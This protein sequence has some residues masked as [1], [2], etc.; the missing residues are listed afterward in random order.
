[1]WL[2]R[3]FGRRGTAKKSESPNDQGDITGASAT[4]REYI[5]THR[6]SKAWGMLSSSTG[7]LK[8]FWLSEE[9]LPSS[10]K[11]DEYTLRVLVQELRIDKESVVDA[12]VA[13]GSGYR[14]VPY[15]NN[16]ILGRAVI[17]AD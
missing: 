10:R 13:I 1:M 7:S 8:G 5:L 14:V 11:I 15:V 6:D 12:Y 2:G 9:Y 4:R 16:G 17:I 3:L